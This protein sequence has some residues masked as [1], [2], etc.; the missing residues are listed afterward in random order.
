M[1]P[2]NKFTPVGELISLSNKKALV[3]GGAMGIGFAI[4]YRLAEAGAIV[5]IADLNEEKGRA[6]VEDLKSKGLNAIFLKCNVAKEEEVTSTVSNA[7]K[8]LGGM[9]ILVNNAGIFPFIPFTQMT[10]D[11]LEKVLAINLKGLFYFSREVS[12][13]MI[14]QQRSGC[15]INI[16]SIDAIHPS[17]IGLSAYDASK[18]GVLMMTKSMAKE[19]G[20]QGIRVNAIAPG[21]IMTEGA[22]AVSSGAATKESTRA[23]MSRIPLGRMGI[24]DDIGRVALFLASDLSNYMTG[25]LVVADGGYLL[26]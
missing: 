26:S 22:I 23:F 14:A 15:I 12:R 20:S 4:A 18:G 7:I 10:A 17:N 5:A 19:L 8:Q 1:N 9:D 2:A 21:S 11:N 25:S 24:A 3:T 13:W 6:A 16:A